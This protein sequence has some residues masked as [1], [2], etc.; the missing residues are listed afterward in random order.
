MAGPWDTPR[1]QPRIQR[2]W[3]FRLSHQSRFSTPVEELL[4]QRHEHYFNFQMVNPQV[5]MCRSKE[6]QMAAVHFHVYRGGGRK[7]RSRLRRTGRAGRYRGVCHLKFAGF[8]LAG[9]RLLW[10]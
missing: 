1:R 7:Q 4:G 6:Q 2:A 10:H 9:L 8:S 3:S 5:S